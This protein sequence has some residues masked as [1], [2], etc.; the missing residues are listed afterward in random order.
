MQRRGWVQHSPVKSPSATGGVGASSPP[1]A[2]FER[3]SRW[4]ELPRHRSPPPRPPRSS[5]GSRSS[6]PSRPS[7]VP[8]PGT[9][10]AGSGG[11]AGFVGG[12]KSGGRNCRARRQRGRVGGS[13]PRP[14]P[15]DTGDSVADPRRGWNCQGLRLEEAQSLS[16]AAPV[17][18]AVGAVEPSADASGVGSGSGSGSG[19]ARPSCDARLNQSAAPRGGRRRL[20]SRFRGRLTPAPAPRSS[21]AA[22]T[23]SRAS[24]ASRVSSPGTFS[25]PLSPAGLAVGRLGTLAAA[26]PVT[27][28]RSRSALKRLRS[29]LA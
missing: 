23:G 11:L 8:Y 7:P 19:T 4:L 27:R 14:N 15:S 1:N 18:T 9:A 10:G 16:V 5:R 29:A 20:R 2:R 26:A 3:V 21:S 25:V 17:C 12:T 24:F 22:G 28:R 6:R 13:W